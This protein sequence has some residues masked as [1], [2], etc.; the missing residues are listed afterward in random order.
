MF[1]EII[2]SVFKIAAINNNKKILLPPLLS[3]DFKNDPVIVASLFVDTIIK[4][5]SSFST[6]IIMVIYDPL[7]RDKN[8]LDEFVS[9][10]SLYNINFDTYYS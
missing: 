9:N 7:R 3:R 2:E 8:I 5:I 1:H 4:K 6:E 10:L